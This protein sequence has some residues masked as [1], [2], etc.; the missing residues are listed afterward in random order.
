MYTYAKQEKDLREKL[1]KRKKYIL[2]KAKWIN[3]I[4]YIKLK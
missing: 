3:R 4:N 2:K 1:N